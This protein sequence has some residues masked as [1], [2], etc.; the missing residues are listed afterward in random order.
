LE[1]LE[2]PGEVERLSALHRVFAS[3]EALMPHHAAA[4]DRLFSGTATRLINLYGPTEATVDVS[5]FNCEPGRAYKHIPIGKPIDNIRLYVIDKTQCLQP[6]G[7]AGELVI[8]G[9]GLARGYLNRSQL[10]AEKFV[11]GKKASSFYPNNQY[12][13]T[14]NQ[15]NNQA[16]NQTPITANVFYRTGDLARWQPDGNI[17]YLGRID[18]QVKIR[19]FRIELGEIEKQLLLHEKIKEVA[20]IDRQTE[21][22]ESYLCAY[23]VSVEQ[24]PSDG[25]DY[26]EFRTHLAHS[27]PEYMIPAYFT[28]IEQLPLTR[29]GKLDRKALPAPGIVPGTDYTAPRNQLEE[30]LTVIWSQIL[31][32]ETESISIDANFFHI[33]GHSLKA[34]IL[35][36]R[37]HKELEV[38]VPLAEIF[39]R[40]TIR[41]LAQYIKETTVERFV[42][43]QAA[44]E[45][46]NYALSSAQK[47]IY[48][49]QQLDEKGSGYNIPSMSILDG[50][51]DKDKFTVVFRRLIKRHE[52]LRTSFL[53]HREQPV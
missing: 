3:G 43:I 6:I 9:D 51:I 21:S 18:H 46:D 1:H 10:T 36:S 39:K 29:S 42:S 16:N 47:R 5:Y 52:S 34:T 37:L 11:K 38:E 40:N 27:L 48:V 24:A 26:R 35:T 19:G 30:K 8:A 45:K 49:L 4:F 28:Q 17:Q 20:V 41:T 33:G 12:P 15:S 50:E 2:I 31:E 7:I 14:N 53:I 44:G 32:I 25:I 23:Y 22:G 13:I